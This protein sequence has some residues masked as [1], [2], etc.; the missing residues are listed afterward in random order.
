MDILGKWVVDPHDSVTLKQLGHV[1]MEF[2]KDGNLLYK[3]FVG[4]KIQ[5]MKLRFRIEGTTIVSDQPSAP[6]EERTPFSLST[7]GVLTL[8]F[9]GVNSRFVR[10]AD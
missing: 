10:R 4:E 2:C 8:T 9:Q 5:I 1:E 7:K 6:R 3:L